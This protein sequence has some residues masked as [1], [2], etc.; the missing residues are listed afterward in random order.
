MA[1]DESAALVARRAWLLNEL[2]QECE[3]TAAERVGRYLRVQ[4]QPIVA[5][6]PFASASAECM[7]LFRDGRF[8]GCISLSQAVGEALVR[9][10]CRSNHW[11][12]AKTFEENV[13]ALRRRG[14]IDEAIEAEMLSLW[15]Q[16][17][18]YHH[19][20]DS[21]ATER[22]ALDELAIAK[23]RALAVIEEWVFGFCHGEAGLVLR[24]PQYWPRTGENQ[25]GV[26]LR[27]DPAV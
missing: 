25:V 22:T 10:M 17:D 1:E 13:G 12:P 27:C 8:Y 16:R 26:F 23:I 24:H 11:R 4:H 18:E 21:I 9:H 15:Q 7:G 3:A 14:F 2:R 6:T 20:N 5:D 19:L